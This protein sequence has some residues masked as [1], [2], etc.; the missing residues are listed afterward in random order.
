MFLKK[1][2]IIKRLV[3]FCFVLNFTFSNQINA[4]ESKLNERIL[5]H[6]NN[7]N[8]F[9]SEFIQIN[10]KSVQEGSLFIKNNRLRIDY[11]KPTDI[12]II[13]KEN[14]A[15]YY[16]RELEEVEYFNPKKSIS[17]I[18]FNLFNDPDFLK[19][20]QIIFEENLVYFKKDISIMDEIYVVNIFFEGTGNNSPKKFSKIYFVIL[21]LQASQPIYPPIFLKPQELNL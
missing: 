9:A 18:F 17:S 4:S 21:Y 7:Y 13:I 14:K 8:E 1:T 11:P 6:L 5:K 3:F 15:M 12:L 19:E 20:S 10:G 2:S 16:N